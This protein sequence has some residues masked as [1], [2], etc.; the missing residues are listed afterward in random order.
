MSFS[1][2]GTFL[3]SSSWKGDVILWDMNL[4]KPVIQLNGHNTGK[5][6][7]YI[8]NLLERH[9]VKLELFIF[10]FILF[11]FYVTTTFKQ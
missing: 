9:H 1:S 4:L 3:A 2:D 11:I 10:Y 6:F 8:G 7:N 5:S